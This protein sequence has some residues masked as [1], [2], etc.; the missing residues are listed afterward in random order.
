MRAFIGGRAGSSD[1]AALHGTVCS[2]CTGTAVSAGVCG[3]G[4]VGYR[5]NGLLAT[6]LVR[7][8]PLQ[9]PVSSL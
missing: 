4:D 8:V 1:A 5:D 7:A 6:E 3:L 2:A 9:T